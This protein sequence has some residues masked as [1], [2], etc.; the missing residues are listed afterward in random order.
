[1]ILIYLINS[2]AWAELYIVMARIVQRFDFR[3]D[4]AGLKDVKP[5]SDQF[6]IGTKDGSGIKA[7]VTVA[8]PVG[9]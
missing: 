1:M 8:K 4:G 3:F 2:L 5:D 7:F 9:F 6:I